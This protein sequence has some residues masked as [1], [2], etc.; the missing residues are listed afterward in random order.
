MAPSF[1]LFVTMFL[2][3]VLLP[4]AEMGP[5]MLGESD[6]CDDTTKTCMTA[7]FCTNWCWC[8][9]KGGYDLGRCF[10]FNCCCFPPKPKP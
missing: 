8:K 2:L 9:K 5:M 7:K 6:K 10:E 3:L 1:K 4:W